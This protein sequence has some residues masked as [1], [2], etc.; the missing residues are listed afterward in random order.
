M[1]CQ[2]V[3]FIN[4]QIHGVALTPGFGSC[5]EVVAGVV[6]IFKCDGDNGFSGVG[7]FSSSGLEANC[8]I[9][10]RIKLWVNGTGTF[11]RFRRILTD[12][13]DIIQ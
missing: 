12:F 1:Q 10:G 8:N 5:R 7:V 6:G 4:G 2:H 9:V 13:C 3:R 11:G